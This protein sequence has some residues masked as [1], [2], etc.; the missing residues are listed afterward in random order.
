MV[1]KADR[2]VYLIGTFDILYFFGSANQSL[3]EI[4]IYW[5][6]DIFMFSVKPNWFVKLCVT[7][8]LRTIEGTCLISLGFIGPVDPLVEFLELS[9]ISVPPSVLFPWSDMIYV[10]LDY[11]PSD[12]DWVPWANLINRAFA[13]LRGSKKRL[14]NYTRVLISFPDMNIS[15]SF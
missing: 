12:W 8:A 2:T 14:C 5:S 13:L 15:R 10:L 7:L 4:Q 6:F 1:P 11:V 9:K 3:H